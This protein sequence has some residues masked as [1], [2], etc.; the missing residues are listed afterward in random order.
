MYTLKNK[1][2]FITGASSGIGRSC[3]RAFAAQGTKLI[4]AARRAER[5]EEL[6]LCFKYPVGEGFEECECDVQVAYED[7]LVAIEA[8][9]EAARKDCQ[10]P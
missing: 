4:L 9:Y 6:E 5:L 3:A 10:N 2:V 7:D 8:D 1:I